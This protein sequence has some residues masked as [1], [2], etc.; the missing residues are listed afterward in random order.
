MTAVVQY[1]V[2]GGIS[3]VT[4]NRP[5]QMSMM[6]DE[7]Q[8]VALPALSGPPTTTGSGWSCLRASARRSVPRATCTASAR[9]DSVRRAMQTLQ[10]PREMPN[11]TIA[12]IHGAYAGAGLAWTCNLR[13]CADTAV[14]STVF[15]TAGL[16][17]EFA[18]TWT[19]PRIVGDANAVDLYLLAEKFRPDDAERIGLVS[20]SVP[21]D[22][23]TNH[24]RRVAERLCTAHV[25]GGEV[26]SG[27]FAA[28]LVRRT[29]RP[30]GRA[31][32]PLRSDRGSPGGR[33]GLP[34]EAPSGLSRTLTL[35][36]G[37]I[38]EGTWSAP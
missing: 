2:D 17:G 14:S 21:A 37:N 34:G 18:D 16:S 4:L 31:E 29:A 1:E 10:L 32:H 3:T 25:G 23:L 30:G 11:A 7:L 19:R 22:E 26:Q 12:Q 28:G 13:Y 36:S 5:V 38:E 15:M 33:R 6:N 20:R 9:I 27:Q 24:L 35:G 8:E